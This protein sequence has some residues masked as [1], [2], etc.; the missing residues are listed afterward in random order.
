MITVYHAK[1][2]RFSVPE[3]FRFDRREFTKVAEVAVKNRDEAY[4]ETQNIHQ[5][6]VENEVIAWHADGAQ[7][8]TSIGDVLVMT[9][10]EAYVAVSFGFEPV[11]TVEE[12]E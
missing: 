10:G 8:S 2:P 9:S 7:R 4:Y 6:W 11:E 5:P 1:A 12:G 3:G